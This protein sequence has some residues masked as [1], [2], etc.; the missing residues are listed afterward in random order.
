MLHRMARALGVP[1]SK[2]EITDESYYPDAYVQTEAELNEIRALSLQVLKN[3]RPLNIRLV[4]E[5]PAT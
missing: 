3:G 2:T 5:P 1:F 4:G